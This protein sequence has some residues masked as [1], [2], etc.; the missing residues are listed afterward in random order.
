LDAVIKTHVV[1][2]NIWDSN[3]KNEELDPQMTEM[4]PE[5]LR[6]CQPSRLCFGCSALRF[7]GGGLSALKRSLG[8]CG[9]AQIL[10]VV[11]SGQTG[12]AVVLSIC[13]FVTVVNLFACLFAHNI[14]SAK[15]DIVVVD[16]HKI[17][18]WVLDQQYYWSLI[19]RP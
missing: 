18:P 4:Y 5:N 8:S 13:M 7:S 6:I 19:I 12:K 2:T 15:E 11:S 10:S 1:T 3:S 14:L 9:Q 16:Q 17:C